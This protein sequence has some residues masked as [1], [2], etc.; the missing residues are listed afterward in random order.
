MIVER[1]WL[2]AMSSLTHVMHLARN[3][4]SVKLE[5]SFSLSASVCSYLLAACRSAVRRNREE[6]GEHHQ[7]K[8]GIIVSLRGRPCLGSISLSIVSLR[9]RAVLCAWVRREMLQTWQILQHTSSWKAKTSIRPRTSLLLA[10]R[11]P[12]SLSL[13]RWP[14]RWS[15]Q[16]RLDASQTIQIIPKMNKLKTRKMIAC[17]AHSLSNLVWSYQK[18]ILQWL[19]TTQLNLWSQ[20]LMISQFELLTII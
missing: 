10:T 7:Q 3:H 6:A 16:M 9:S 11:A 2:R 15:F 17:T 20:Y 14:P 1:L 8:G 12:F 18:P 5:R 4:R 13:P 19:T